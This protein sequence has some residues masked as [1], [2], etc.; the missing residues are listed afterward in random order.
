[1]KKLITVIT[2]VTLIGCEYD[3]SLQPA[4]NT[5]VTDRPDTR[6]ALTI[7]DLWIVFDQLSLLCRPID[8]ITT[9]G[10]DCIDQLTVICQDE[11]GT[12]TT[13][14]VASQNDV[15]HLVLIYGDLPDLTD[16]L[17]DV[18]DA[19]CKPVDQQVV[20]T[21]LTYSALGRRAHPPQPANQL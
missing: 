19:E 21:D 10:D 12:R 3:P 13:V 20:C 9:C 17:L 18:W 14:V 11:W 2:L 5:I 16:A 6:G 15:V 8:A 1:M 4:H 7:G